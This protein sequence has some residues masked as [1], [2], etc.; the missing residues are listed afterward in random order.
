[1]GSLEEAGGLAALNRFTRIET[2]VHAKYWLEIVLEKALPVTS[3]AL[4]SVLSRIAIKLLVIS[5]ITW[6]KSSRR[7]LI[8]VT[9]RIYKFVKLEGPINNAAALVQKQIDRDISASGIMTGSLSLIALH[10]FQ[11]DR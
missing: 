6:R 11:L 9:S 8:F 2:T 4:A 3:L 5:P 1:M 7:F 10:R